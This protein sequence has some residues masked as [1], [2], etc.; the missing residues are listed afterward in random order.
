MS[1]LSL[2]ACNSGGTSAASS[3]TPA[4]KTVT[5]T[6]SPSSE[7][8]TSDISS[9]TSTDSSSDSTSSDMS[10]TSTD[11][12]SDISTDVPSD[13][14]SS[15]GPP[16][17]SVHGEDK[18][19]TL[20]DAFSAYEW[21][22]GSFTPV[23]ATSPVSAASRS[24]RIDCGTVFGGGDGLEYRFG[25]A[26]G[27]LHFDFAQDSASVSSSNTIEVDLSVNGKTTATK[28][29]SFSESGS[30]STNLAGVNVVDINFKGVSSS[31]CRG[32]ANLLMTKVWITAQ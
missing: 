18:T 23:G 2:T 3:I 20:Q 13:G 5:V 9:D 16:V 32:S 30:L 6:A 27:T 24:P 10:S 28:A 8:S 7:T 14:A 31:E 29:I 21:E 22:T 12:S 1:A 15:S 25:G 17:L 26:T 11:M 4:A 19:L